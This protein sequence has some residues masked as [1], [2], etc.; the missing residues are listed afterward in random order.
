MNIGEAI[1]TLRKTNAV[2]QKDLAAA[3]AVSATHLSLVESGEQKPSVDLIDRIANH[4]G[5]PV[6]AIVYMALDMDKLENEEQ[7][8]YFEAAKPIIDKLMTYL[9]SDNSTMTRRR[10]SKVVIK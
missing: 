1:K 4:F 8:K 2:K 3:V 10:S 5:I 7:Q 6:S 9:L